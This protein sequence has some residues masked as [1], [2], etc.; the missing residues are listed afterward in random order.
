MLLWQ[1]MEKTKGME[2]KLR[3]TKEEKTREGKQFSSEIARISA[4]L[5][6]EV[7]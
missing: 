6:Q 3:E 5:Q 1:L 7:L 2:E 4:Q